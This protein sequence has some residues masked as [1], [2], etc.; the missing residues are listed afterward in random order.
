MRTALDT[1]ILSALWGRESPAPRIAAYLDAAGA[2]VISPI[3][4][5]ESRA[6]PYVGHDQVD[7][8]LETMRVAVDWMLEREVWEL[9]AERF[10]QY[11]SRR[12]GQGAGEAKRVTSDFVIGAHALLRADRLITLDQRRYRTDFPELILLTV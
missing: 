10:E 5:M 1:N 11:A 7:Q 12:R 3:V 4:Y 6:H 8:F 2:L 9:A